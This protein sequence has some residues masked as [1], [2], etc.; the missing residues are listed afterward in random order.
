MTALASYESLAGQMTK[1]A[2]IDRMSAI[3]ML[4]GVTG[5]FNQVM[6]ALQAWR[7]HVDSAATESVAA[8]GH[9]N[10]KQRLISWMVVAAVNLVALLIV[11]VSSRS[12]TRPLRQLEMR[13]IA[14]TEGDLESDISDKQLTNEIGRMA[15]ALDVFKANAQETRRLQGEAGREQALKARRQA[16]MDRHTQDFGTTVAGVMAS[17]ARSAEVMRATAAEMSEAAHRSRDSA[18]QAADGANLSSSNLSAV[19]AAAE[20]M[21]SSL[22]EV[23][24]QVGRV[25][26]A[27]AEAVG[28][29]DVTESKVG[30]M[31]ASAD[32]V[33]DVVKLI[34]DI[35][36]RTNLLALNAT[37]EAARA[38]EAGKG[39]AVVAGEVKALATQTAKATDEIAMQIAAIRASTGEAVDS[40]RNVSHAI[41]A[42]NQVAAAIAAA[43]EQQAAATA[44]IVSRVQS[45][46]AT[47]HDSARAIQEV[48][49]IS[50]QTDAASGKVLDGSAQVG[51]D[52]DTLRGEVTQFL[53]AM[54]GTS[55]EDRRLYERNPGNGAHGMLR[56]PGQPGTRVAIVDISRGGMAL[57][58]DWRG[59]A[60]TE[61]R[62]ELP[63]TDGVVVARCVR[64]VNGML[65]LAFNQGE[66][67]LSRVDQ[68]L[69]HIQGLPVNRAA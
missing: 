47:T 5:R 32:R 3:S 54:A 56:L 34:T 6:A 44:E 9:D 10:D 62:L 63:G 4:R 20:Q 15:R 35:A 61:V 40:V 60:G 17:L 51:R 30:S 39:F 18:T 28:L 11:Y 12:I 66:E 29:A 69:A 27:V 64:S 8:A 68:A 25:T 36:G 13:M 46:S 23:S 19:S 2:E 50:E 57:R 22:N 52:A 21:S 14:L 45:V 55:D 43:V 65:G 58:T 48:S 49:A 33:G 16:A 38:G 31:A 59:D 24:H 7:S 26:Q 41:D 67:T 1:S 53:A 42:V 37:I